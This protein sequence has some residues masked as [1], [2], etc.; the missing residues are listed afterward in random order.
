[1]GKGPCDKKAKAVH[2]FSDD[3]DLGQAKRALAKVVADARKKLDA[4]NE[5]YENAGLKFIELAWYKLDQ[6]TEDT[7]ANKKADAQAKL[8]KAEGNLDQATAE[9]KK[10]KAFGTKKG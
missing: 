1:M 5:K 10:M 4:E 6:A 9:F 3:E 2:G 8:K 7:K